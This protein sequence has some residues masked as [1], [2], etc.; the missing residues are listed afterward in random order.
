MKI[1]MSSDRFPQNTNGGKQV[2]FLAVA[3]SVGNE[4][5]NPG[6]P[7]K[8]TT[9]GMVY[10]GLSHQQD[11]L[12]MQANATHLSPSPRPNSSRCSIGNDVG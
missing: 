12:Q 4:G 2:L 7:L 8:E 5:M 6:V 10:R 1:A 3:K 11:F 9:S